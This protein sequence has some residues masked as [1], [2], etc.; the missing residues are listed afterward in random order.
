VSDL[1]RYDMIPFHHY[2]L[3]VKRSDGIVEMSVVV[4]AAAAVVPQE[5]SPFV[6][7]CRS[8]RVSY[9]SCSCG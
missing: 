1:L 9:V 6:D 5:V 8:V 3:D 2:D 4:V 7:W